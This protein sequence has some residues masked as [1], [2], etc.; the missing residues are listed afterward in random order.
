MDFQAGPVITAAHRVGCVGATRSPLGASL[1][2]VLSALDLIDAQ[3][4][5]GQLPSAVVIRVGLPSAAMVVAGLL[6]PRGADAQVALRREIARRWASLRAHVGGHCWLAGWQ[7]LRPHGWAERAAAL[8][9]HGR[10][11]V[12]GELSPLW[13]SAD[14]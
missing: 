8:A 2:A 1:V 4:R 7:P 14:T 11:G 3:L 10:M 6:D 5:S 13:Q 12:W 9:E